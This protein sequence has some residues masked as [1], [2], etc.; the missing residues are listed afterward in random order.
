MRNR[1]PTF[2]AA[3]CAGTIAR[4]G[5]TVAAWA[6]SAALVAGSLAAPAQAVTYT[7]TQGLIGATSTGTVA[8]S[9]NALARAQITG[10]TDINFPS[11]DPATSTAA[12]ASQNDCV[13]SNTSNK[14]YTIT[15]TGSGTSGAFTLAA[16]TKTV[17]Y[18]VQWAASASASSGTPLANGVASGA[19]VSTAALPACFGGSAN[20]TL[21]VSIAQADVQTMT[22][23][24]PYTGALTLVITPQ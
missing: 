18:S 16:S 20:S 10:L 19:L 24:T 13:W 15:A 3:P 6:V 9:A 7:T 11:L 1:K 2:A 14:N 17:T 23:A 12:S 22:A 8:I 21:I 4:S 5:R